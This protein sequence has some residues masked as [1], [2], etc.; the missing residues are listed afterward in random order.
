MQSEQ[1]EKWNIHTVNLRRTEQD[2]ED[3]NSITGIWEMSDESLNAIN[4][5]QTNKQINKYNKIPKSQEIQKS[6]YA[7]FPKDF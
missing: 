3:Q 7:A 5:K 1:G 2:P 4:Q 6:H